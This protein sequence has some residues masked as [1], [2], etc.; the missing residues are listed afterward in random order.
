[1]CPDCL[2]RLVDAFTLRKLIRESEGA[3][4][5]LAIQMKAEKAGEISEDPLQLKRMQII[6]E[7]TIANASSASVGKST[8][9]PTMDQI[10]S[11]E[12]FETYKV[13]RLRGF[14]CCGCQEILPSK[15]DMVEHSRQEHSHRAASN[16]RDQ[17]SCYIWN[18]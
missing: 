1:M 8:T 7:Q 2:E 3:L 14:R 5:S 10:D 18:E 13:I 12:T 6:S 9:Y 17:V 11:V 4:Q 16:S 15:N